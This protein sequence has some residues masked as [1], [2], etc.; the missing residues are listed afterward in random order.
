MV[1]NTRAPARPAAGRPL[2]QPRP[3]KVV[4]S[5]D[6]PS[7]IFLK[8]TPAPVASVEDTWRLDDEWWRERPISRRYFECVLEEG[9]RLTVFKDLVTGRWYRQT[10]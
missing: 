7:E 2:I 3:V 1:K 10:G 8:Q 6:G 5:K 4:E 9:R